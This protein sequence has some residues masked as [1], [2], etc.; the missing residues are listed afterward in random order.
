L[1][2]LVLLAVGG[3]ASSTVLAVFTDTATSTGNTFASGGVDIAASPATAA[4]TLTNMA[5][6]SRV[7]APIDVSN[8]GS[9]DLR[10][11]VQAATT[12]DAFASVLR[13]SVKSGVATC[14]SAG[15]DGGG[16]VVA[17]P[18]PVGTTTGLALIGDAAVGADPGD[19]DLASGLSEQLCLDVTFPST[20]GNGSANSSTTATF[21]FLAEQTLANP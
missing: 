19:R 13:L 14:T 3:L 12:E 1:S 5:P 9:L 7:T 17:G 8:S 21:T 11:A 10:Y 15:F 4:I 18:G 2:A 20:A 6:G 16:T